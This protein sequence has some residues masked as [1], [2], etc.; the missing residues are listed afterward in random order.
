MIS[1]IL[2]LIPGLFT[3]LNGITNAIANERIAALNAK[4]DQERVAAQERANT[5]QARRDV[6]VAESAHSSINAWIRA[7]IALGPSIYLLKIF[8]WDKVLQSVTGGSTDPLDP[9]LWVVVQTVLGF[10]FLFEASTGVAR[11]FKS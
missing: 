8:L 3:T 10:Y 2:G 11:I 5:L 4:T 7:M 6:M 9:N 1:F